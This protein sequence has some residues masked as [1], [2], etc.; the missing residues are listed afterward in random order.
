MRR[1]PYR[2]PDHLRAARRIN[3]ALLPVVLLVSACADL[4]QPRGAEAPPDPSATVITRSS[5]SLELERYYT[6]IQNRFLAQGLLRTDGGGV[7]T[8]FS[9]RQLVENFTRIALYE[10]YAL[11][12][13]RF[14]AG[15]TESRL[16]RW[17]DPVRV[18]VLFGDSVPP[19]QRA[20]DLRTITQYVR[21]LA[22]L[23][24]HDIRM[25]QTGGNYHVFVM[26]V[27]ELART[28][29]RVRAILPGLPDTTV[30]DITNPDRNIFCAVYSYSPSQN[31]SETTSALAV[32]RSEHPELMRRSCIHEELAQGL[33]LVNDSPAARPS[34]FND[35]E[36]FATLTTHDEILLKMLYDKR[37]RPGMTPAEAR[38]TIETIA[39]EYYS[40]GV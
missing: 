30:D 38:P 40:D 25:S 33:G 13:G 27:D 22:R 31:T 10:E 23:T 17:S 39:A 37:L 26:S 5:A 11:R 19:E 6:R 4:V 29:D 36:E 21:R 12:N 34:I 28:G 7:D 2:R 20:S 18:Q 16:S 9:Q 15:E 8:P 1:L 3:W 32:I 35:D 24:G 14:V